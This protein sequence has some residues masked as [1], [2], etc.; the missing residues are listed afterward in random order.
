MFNPR[1]R[2]RV[3]IAFHEKPNYAGQPCFFD[4]IPPS[5]GKPTLFAKDQMNLVILTFILLKI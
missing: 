5:N 2:K 1:K 3:Q 4:S